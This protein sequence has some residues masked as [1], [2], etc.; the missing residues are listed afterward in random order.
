MREILDISQK[1]NSTQKVK[2][3]VSNVHKE[4]QTEESVSERP[5]LV[6]QEVTVTLPMPPQ[7][8][9]PPRSP[10]L[11]SAGVKVGVAMNATQFLGGLFYQVTQVTMQI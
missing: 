9:P 5:G 8:K 7:P 4:V 1:N 11:A 10:K 2:K 6:E 3:I